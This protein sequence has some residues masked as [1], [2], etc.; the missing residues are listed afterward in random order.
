MHGWHSFGT[1]TVGYRHIKTT[2]WAGGAPSGNT[3]FIM[4]G[5]HVRGYRYTTA[6]ILDTQV[7]FHNWDGVYANKNIVENGNWTS[8]VDV[9]TSSDG[10]VVLRIATEAYTGFVID[11][12]QFFDYP[13]RDIRILAETQSAS[14]TYY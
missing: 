4:G 1:S 14:A 11:L 2:L 6:G 7:Y 3:Q 13:T 8:A 5:W 9:Y 10:Y 12:H